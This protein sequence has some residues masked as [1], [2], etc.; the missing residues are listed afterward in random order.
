[1]KKY[2]LLSAI[3]CLA[4]TVVRAQNSRNVLFLGNSYTAVN[5][6]PQMLADIAAS[7]GDTL[8]FDSNTPGGYTFQN[9]VSNPQ[10]L[11]KI[12]VGNWDYVVL[13]E[14]SQFPSFPIEQVEAEV[15]PYAQ[16]LD[17]LIHHYNTCAQTLFYMTWGRKNGDAS[18]CPNWPPVCTY[19]GMD[20]L[21]HL[22]YMMMADSNHALVSPVGAVWKYLR[23]NY[24][25]IEL[26][27]ADESHPSIAGTYAAAC[28]F[29]TAVF[30]KDPAIISFNSSLP[31]SDAETIK[32]AVKAVVFD[33][34]MSWYIGAYDPV[35]SF[36]VS[37]TGSMVSLTNTSVHATAFEWDFGDGN[38]DTAANPIHGYADEGNYLIQLNAQF[39]KL[40]DTEAVTIT[41]GSSGMDNTWMNDAFRV[42]P[43]PFHDQLYMECNYSGKAEWLMSTV[44][45]RLL[46]PEWHREGN[47]IVLH[48]A[49][50]PAGVYFLS[51]SAGGKTWHQKIVKR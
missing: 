39:C 37:A 29:Y 6:L 47:S 36:E 35:A 24:P 21:L 49:N 26:Y 13:Q 50:L 17:S 44:S 30:R 41:V 10:T 5:N 9:H 25:A 32:A 12:M 46:N 38:T 14:Q 22:R 2:I 43:N 40:S 8:I 27:Q 28:C 45:G 42:F 19:E 48:T 33:S 16:Q 1:M 34:M 23:E 51:I 7:T 20:S 18:N 15:F 11:N 3:L 31:T 4:I